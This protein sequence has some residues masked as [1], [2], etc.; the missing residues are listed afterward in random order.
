LISRLRWLRVAWRR[1]QSGWFWLLVAV[2]LVAIGLATIALGSSSASRW[3]I[4]AGIGGGIVLLVGCLYAFPRAVT[5]AEGR[6][7]IGGRRLSLENEIR[8]TLVQMLLGGVILLGAASTWQQLVISRDTQVTQQFTG[9]VGQLGQK[10]VEVRLGAIYTLERVARTAEP[11]DRVT[12]YRLLAGF[13]RVHS[14]WPPPLKEIKR[15]QHSM[16]RP[17]PLEINSLRK[18]SP[19]VQAAMDVISAPGKELPRGQEYAPFLVDVDLRGVLLQPGADL[20]G[21]DLRGAALDYLDG[22]VNPGLTHPDLR[23]AYLRN[24]SLRCAQLQ[25]VDLRGAD[26]RGADLRDADLKA[27]E[28]GDQKDAKIDRNTKLNGALGNER[29]EWPE[30]FNQ[31][32]DSNK[33]KLQSD[34]MSEPPGVKCN[35]P[36]PHLRPLQLHCHDDR[37]CTEAEPADATK[38]PPSRPRRLGGNA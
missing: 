6:G 1:L 24:A 37:F 21:A 28:T 23:G 9:A 32:P 30:S 15:E 27:D 7:L 19:D 2:M 33:V 38:V 26:L 12:V 18:R 25:G 10:P 5:G 3:G 20:R 13:V 16:S 35:A 14:Q 11:G 8:G 17:R 4:W 31:H 36:D 22:R 34:I 29:T